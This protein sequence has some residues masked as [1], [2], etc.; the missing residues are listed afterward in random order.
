MLFRSTPWAV[1]YQAPQSMGFSREE[2]WS[3]LSFPSPGDLPD[4]GIEAGSLA[5]QV[6]S[7]PSEP[8]GKPDNLSICALSIELWF[9]NFMRLKVAHMLQCL[10]LTPS[11]LFLSG[12]FVFQELHLCVSRRHYAL[13]RGCRL[14]G[15]LPG[16][17]SVRVRAT[18]LAGNGS[19][20][21]ATYFYVTD[22]C[23]SARPLRLV[24]SVLGAGPSRVFQRM[25]GEAWRLWVL[26]L[27]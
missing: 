22:Y 4:P 23:K 5:L 24:E 17:Y 2:Y 11:M 8:P 20:T 12:I 1:A 9:G 13:E 27:T 18:S 7:L 15:L 16:N 21:E 3:R 10:C 6:D 19:W 25:L 14:R 26:P